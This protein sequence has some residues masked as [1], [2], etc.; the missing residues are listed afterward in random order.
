MSG[1]S[2]IIPISMLTVDGPK[3]RWVDTGLV[4][5]TGESIVT[6]NPEYQPLGFLADLFEED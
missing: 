2:P 5:A 4:T 6:R 3:E 1:G